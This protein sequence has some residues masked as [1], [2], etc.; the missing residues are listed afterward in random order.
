MSSTLWLVGTLGIGACI[1]LAG[2]WRTWKDFQDAKLGYPTQDER[3]LKIDGLAAKYT[4]NIGSYFMIALLLVLIISTEFL[5]SPA[6]NA[7]FALISS[8][9]VF[10]LTFLGLRW[11]FNRKGDF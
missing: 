8:I 2:I 5:G 7:G 9:L 10:S 1:I 4:L 6:F 3:T 11:Y